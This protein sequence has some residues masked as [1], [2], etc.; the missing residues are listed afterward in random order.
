MSYSKEIKQFDE[1]SK[2]ES[3]SIHMEQFVI[4]IMDK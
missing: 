4:T 1:L 3:S 2:K